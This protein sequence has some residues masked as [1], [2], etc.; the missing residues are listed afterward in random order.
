M[1]YSA[2]IIENQSRLQL[3]EHF[4]PKFSDVIAHHVTFKFPDQFAPPLCDE[5]IVVGYAA[6]DKV[7]CVVV[8][9]RGSV[10]RPAG[11]FFH[12]TLSVDRKAG[13][14]PVHSNRLLKKG[15]QA[16]ERLSL[17]VKAALIETNGSKSQSNK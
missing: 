15:W 9:V 16:V 13:A 5:V 17:D 10:D 7:E 14:K 11:G 12:I 2:Y 1:G 3:L 6:N 8:E 4:P